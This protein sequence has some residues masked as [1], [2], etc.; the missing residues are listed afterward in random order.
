[1]LWPDDSLSKKIF[2]F[3]LKR[4]SVITVVGNNQK[5]ALVRLGINPNSLFVIPNTFDVNIEDDIDI[6]EKFKNKKSINI[7]HLSLLIESKG[8]PKYLDALEII[9]LQRKDLI[10]EA[11]LCGPLSF[12]SYC[13]RFKN[14]KEKTT[15]I[16]EKLAKINSSES[17]TIK[18]IKGAMGKEKEKIFRDADIFVFPTEF[19]V[20]AQPLVLLEAMASGCALI[21]STAGEIL[22]TVD[23]KCAVIMSEISPEILANNISLLCENDSLRKDM[24]KH[25]FERVKAKFSSEV[26]LANWLELL[27][28]VQTA[29]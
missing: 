21:T 3:L 16:K 23:D 4:A 6:E 14:A 12:T 1:M 29:K 17:V 26:Y 13:N 20:E 27:N 8:F 5:N 28:Y 25:G 19:P 22:S 15:W 2:F 9:A 7:L 24:A 10:I 11:I 18:W